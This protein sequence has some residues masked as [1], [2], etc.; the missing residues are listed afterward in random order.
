MIDVYL[1]G[2]VPA[3]GP[4]VD[5]TSEQ[6]V[7]AARERPGSVVAELGIPAGWRMPLPRLASADRASMIVTA[8]STP[9]LLRETSQALVS[10]LAH[11]SAREVDSAQAPP[12]VGAPAEVTSIVAEVSP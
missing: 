6:T 1:S 3:L 2:G 4:G 8:G 9:A 12:H 10:R 11:A 7:A 5:R